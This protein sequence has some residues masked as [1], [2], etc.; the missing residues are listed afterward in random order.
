MCQFVPVCVSLLFVRTCENYL[1][2]CLCQNM[3]MCFCNTVRGSFLCQ[4]AR[5]YVCVP[6]GCHFV[7]SLCI[8]KYAL[9]AR[10]YLFAYMYIRMA[11][12]NA[13]RLFMWVSAIGGVCIF[14]P[15]HKLRNL[16]GLVC[17]WT[18]WRNQ[19]IRSAYVI[20]WLL[21]FNVYWID[22]NWTLL[23]T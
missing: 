2:V 19:A 23:L 17:E 9:L 16:V 3:S 13:F 14:V 6:F 15:I 22:N 4:Y 5:I 7:P 18:V 1:V 10:V 8:L 21:Y 20:T 11:L 12:T